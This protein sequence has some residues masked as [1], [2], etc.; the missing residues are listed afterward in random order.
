MGG[1]FDD[2]LQIPGAHIILFL[3]AYMMRKSIKASPPEMHNATEDFFS[4]S[5]AVRPIRNVTLLSLDNEYREDTRWVIAYILLLMGL[6]KVS[7]ETSL[8][9]TLM[10]ACDTLLSITAKTD[11]KHLTPRSPTLAFTPH[12]Y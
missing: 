1:Q 8:A 3:L 9:A 11:K 10:E 12:T 7:G 2:P 5:L 4:N 6:T